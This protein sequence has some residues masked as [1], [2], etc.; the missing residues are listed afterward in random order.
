MELL[1]F[2]LCAYGLTQIL[3]YGKILDDIRPTEGKLGELFK[4]PYVHGFP[5]R[6]VFNATFSVHRTI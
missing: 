6:M 2:I 3:V 5:C 4:M 1:A